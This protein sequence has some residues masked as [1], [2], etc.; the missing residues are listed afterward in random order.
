MEQTKYKV[1]RKF[2]GDKK[3]EERLKVYILMKMKKK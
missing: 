1:I 3:L 2:Q